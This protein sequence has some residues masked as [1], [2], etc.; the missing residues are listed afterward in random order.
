M[1]WKTHITLVPNPLQFLGGIT[2]MLLK[3]LGTL[4]PASKHAKGIQNSGEST[5]KI[6]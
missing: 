3:N 6:L 1:L 4:K 5:F 2:L